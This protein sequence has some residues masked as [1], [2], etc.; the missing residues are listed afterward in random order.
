[1]THL[2]FFLSFSPSPPP[3]VGRNGSQTIP[4][5]RV[6]RGQ[7]AALSA[8]QLELGGRA[9]RAKSAHRGRHRRIDDREHP[10]SAAELRRPLWPARAAGGPRCV[11]NC[12][13]QSL[14]ATPLRLVRVEHELLAQQ[15]QPQH[16]WQCGTYAPAE[17]P[18]TWQQSGWSGQ[19]YIKCWS[20][21]YVR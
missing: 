18:C 5:A 10:Q 15:Q 19:R 6:R 17:P 16:G 21:Q 4:R 1:M 13:L 2:P 11:Y 3:S 8:H 12:N 7:G 14:P 9:D 20:I